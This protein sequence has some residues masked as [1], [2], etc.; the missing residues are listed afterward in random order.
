MKA[1]K[2]MYLGT[3]LGVEVLEEHDGR[4]LPERRTLEGRRAVSL[5]ASNELG[6][7]Y[8]G[9][10]YHGV[11]RSKDSGQSWEQVLEA[12]VRSL[13]FDP[14]DPAVAYAGTEPVHL[15][16]TADGGDSWTE[17][18]GLQRVPE[19]V[20][21]KWWFP[22]YP[23]DSHVLSVY[24][25][26][27]DSRQV[28]VGLEHGGILRTDDGG[29]TWE[30]VSA[31]I[32][33]LDIHMVGGDPA[34]QN[35][36]YAATARGF[37]RSKDYGRGWILSDRGLA[38]DYM[39]DFV[40]HPGPR[41]TLFM[42]TANG[43]PPNWTRDSR[44]QSALFRS[45]DEG[46]SWHMLGGGLPPAMKR[47]IWNVAGDPLDQDRLY[48]CAGDY[49]DSMPRGAVLGGEVWISPDRGGTWQQLHEVETP[50]HKVCPSLA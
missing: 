17:L 28:Y 30:D 8:A 3:D 41:S 44:A 35:L 26:S 40:V 12:D 49:P 32:E 19:P 4:W 16:R 50:I 37:Y 1:Q 20:Q 39:H 48:A 27:H 31:G 29:D 42:T 7:V 43:T 34:R 6:I 21:E 9:V 14:S 5:V 2:R 13:A 47:M 22:I 10:S 25:S 46:A 33:Y 18:E 38:R 45:D 15:Y 36:V 11:F 23:H 24:V